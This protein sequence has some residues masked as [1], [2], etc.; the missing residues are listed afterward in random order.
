MTTK[1]FKS[2]FERAIAI[3]RFVEKRHK[4]IEEKQKKLALYYAHKAWP[5]GGK[6]DASWFHLFHNWTLGVDGWK[7][8]EFAHKALAAWHGAG[9]G[10]YERQS[11]IWTAAMDKYCR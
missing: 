1:Q 9:K 7:T 10:H 4:R 8:N 3:S 11:K 6:P 5:E 2:G